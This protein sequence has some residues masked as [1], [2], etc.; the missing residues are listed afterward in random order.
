MRWIS[1]YEMIYEMEEGDRP[2]EDVINDDVKLDGWYK[3]YEAYV[4]KISLKNNKNKPW[5]N[6]DM[7]KASIV[8]GKE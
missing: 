2:I 7:P 8:M 5:A 1:F 6:R 3:N 4:R